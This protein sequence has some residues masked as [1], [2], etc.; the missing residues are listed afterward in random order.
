ML[1]SITNYRKIRRITVYDLEWIPGTLEVRVVGVYDERGYRWYRTVKE[2]LNKELTSRNRGRWFYAHAG[3]LADV[4]F[5]LEEIVDRSRDGH[6]LQ[7]KSCFSGSSAI[8]V[9]AIFG[10]NVFWF[11]DSYWLFRDKLSNIGHSMGLEKGGPEE[12]DP[13]LSDEEWD[14]L[15][16]KRRA[17][18]RDVPLM[19]LVSYNEQDCLILYRAII[20]FQ[21]RL[22]EWGGQLQM[23]IASCSM[24]LFRRRFLRRDISIPQALNDRARL[25]YCASRVEVVQRRVDYSSNY[26]DINSSFPYSMTF[27][28]P[29]DYLGSSKRIPDN[30]DLY[31]ADVE[32]EVP[33]IQFLP[34]L[35][36]RRESGR[37][38][39][40][41]GQWR[42]WYTS[43]DLE[44]LR[45]SGGRL[46][47]SHEVLKFSAF[48]DLAHYAKTFFDLRAATKDPFERLLFKYILNS[49]YGKFAEGRTKISLWIDPADTEGMDMLFPGA[50]L[51]EEEVDIEHEHV[52]ISSFIV[53]RSRGFLWD[54]TNNLCREVHYMDTDGFSTTEHLSNGSGK[55]GALKL[56]KVLKEG[57]FLHP[58]FY[59]MVMENGDV[60]LKGKGFSRLNQERWWRLA[61]GGSIEYERLMRIR[62]RWRRGLTTPIEDR[63][64]KRLQ[65]NKIPKRFTYP[66]GYTRPWTI[67]ELERKAA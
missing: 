12:P 37:I 60:L 14:R 62:E 19:E 4:Q 40:P 46:L 8:I 18:Y 6:S 39:F 26:F 56:E 36:V 16:K 28:L 58:K 27:P 11:V 52:A 51:F 31:I 47:K 55:L 34:P 65:A 9:K 13:I 50:F 43:V 59:S 7:C 32:I 10:H 1:T 2:F 63:I 48:N 23:T 67:N 15:E 3:G 41:T 30:D 17:W 53:S 33:D 38:F 64:T 29:C 24:N 44:I 22:L 54:W 20:E 66:D 25:S 57:W 5:I 21:S 35:P 61:E 42:G 45:Q 49:L